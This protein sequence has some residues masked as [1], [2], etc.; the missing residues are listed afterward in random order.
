MRE[1]LVSAPD[2]LANGSDGRRKKLDPEFGEDRHESRWPGGFERLLRLPNV[3][4][5]DLAVRFES[6]VIEPSGRAALTGCLEAADCL[7]VLCRRE[8]AVPEMTDKGRRSG[9]GLGPYPSPPADHQEERRSTGAEAGRADPSRRRNRRDPRPTS[10]G[11]RLTETS[12]HGE[13]GRHG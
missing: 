3:E 13:D 11:N 12:G 6:N 5:F 8:S 1:P 10:G 2:D 9:N 7:V 4:H